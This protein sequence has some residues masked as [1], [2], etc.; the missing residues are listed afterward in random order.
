MEQYLHY[1]NSRRR[2]ERERDKNSIFKKMADKL[3]NLWREMDFMKLK[4][5]KIA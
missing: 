1:G 4:S 5:H 2:R 3:P